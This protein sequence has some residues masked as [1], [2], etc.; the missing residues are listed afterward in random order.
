M[1]GKLS[2]SEARCR[3]I[4]IGRDSDYT[5]GTRERVSVELPHSGEQEPKNS[6]RIKEIL[7]ELP[8]SSYNK[9]S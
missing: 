6:I 5:R 2:R 9:D 1:I 4:P 3:A 7:I 8:P